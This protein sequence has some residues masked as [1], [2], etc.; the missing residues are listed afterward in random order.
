MPKVGL[1]GR[2]FGKWFQMVKKWKQGNGLKNELFE[3]ATSRSHAFGDTLEVGMG[4]T[5]LGKKNEQ[6]NGKIAI[7]ASLIF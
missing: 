3:V 6:Q 4:L 1:L 7:F 5:F 2:M